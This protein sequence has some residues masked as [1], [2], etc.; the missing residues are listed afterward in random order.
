MLFAPR[1]L[2]SRLETVAKAG[3]SLRPGA[4]LDQRLARR[5]ILKLI[6]MSVLLTVA[7]NEVQG[8]KT[9]FRVIKNGRYNSNFMRVRIGNRDWQLLGTWESLLRAIIVTAQGKPQEAVRGMGSGL[10]SLTWDWFSG[11]DFLGRN[12]KDDAGNWSLWLMRSFLPFSAEE[13]P[14]AT[15]QIIRG[16]KEEDVG[17]ALGGVSTVTCE[18]LGWKSSPLSFTDLADDEARRLGFD[19]Y[20]EVEPFIRDRI[21][22]SPEVSKKVEEGRNLR[23]GEDFAKYKRAVDA[24]ND[25][26]DVLYQSLID[27]FRKPIRVGRTL[28]RVDA[29]FIAKRYLDREGAEFNQKQGAARGLAVEFQEVDPSDRGAVLLEKWYALS[30]QALINGIF[31]FERLIELREDFIKGLDTADHKYLLRNTNR[32]PPPEELLNILIKSKLTKSTVSRIRES[33]K[34][35]KAFVPQRSPVAVP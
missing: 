32:N 8:R 14:E 6:G 12:V 5:S 10:V 15:M 19:S 24:I 20:S 9:D 31:V 13:L 22:E 26:S 4:T 16:S 21:K 34:A 17:K 35:R 7:I 2:M 23:Q 1:F 25:E 29:D 3:L 28:K 30:D 11:E 27:N 18:I 33:I